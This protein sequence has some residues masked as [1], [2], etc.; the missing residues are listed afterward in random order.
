MAT[1]DVTDALLKIK[2]IKA[3]RYVIIN[4]HRI[5]FQDY[6]AMD[7]QVKEEL[8]LESKWDFSKIE[9]KSWDFTEL[10]EK[11]NQLNKNWEEEIDPLKK[12]I[13]EVKYFLTLEDWFKD[14]PEKILELKD[15]LIKLENLLK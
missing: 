6:I 2:S 11:L 12:E 15:K 7:E 5:K 3:P 13:I 9:I 8:K 10:D 4:G 14:Q 1:I